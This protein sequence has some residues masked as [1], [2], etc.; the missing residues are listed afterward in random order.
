MKSKYIFLLI[1]AA[2][3]TGCRSDLLDTNPYNSIGS[4]VMWG[5]EKLADQGVVGIYNNL[6]KGSVGRRLYTYDSYGFTNDY[7][8]EDNL[9][10]GKSTVSDGVFQTYWQEH[11]EGIHRANDA[12]TNM[13]KA[14]MSAEKL[15]R[16]MAESKILRAYFYYK[17]NMVYKGVPL[18]LEPVEI[19]DMTAPRETEQRIWEVVIQD[20]T[21]AINEPNL[22]D[23]YGASDGEYGR[24]GK[25]V[26]YALRGKVYLWTK[27]WAKAESD[28]KK[29]G[30]LGHKLFQGEYKSL[31]KAENERN[32]EMIFS[33]QC[34]GQSGFGND[35]SFRYGGRTTFGS[36]WNTYYP[37]TDFVETFENADGSKF[38][39]DEVI[40]GYTDLPVND[41]VVY[42][43]R[44]EDTFDHDTYKTA[45]NT[46]QQY[47]EKY[48][49]IYMPDG[50]E[51]RI[52]KAYDNRDP[53]LKAS[54]ITPYSTYLGSA[55]GTDYLYTFRWPAIH[56][57]EGEPFDVRTDT[58]GEYHYLYRKFVAEG[59]NEI[60]NREYS[61][62]DIPL[63]R[64]ADVL[65]NLAE[66]LN[67]QG[68]AK[69]G[70]AI[71]VV[72][73]VRRR[74]GVAELNSNAHTQVAGQ[75]D[76]RERIRNERRWELCGE[77]I[78]FFDEMRWQTL[79]QTKFGGSN[80]GVKEIWGKM[81]RTYSW[82]GEHYYVWPIPNYERQMNTSLTQNPGWG[83]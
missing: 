43:L 12:I 51:E 33:V 4:G 28:F 50:N 32:E 79:H 74:A 11:Y 34:V 60:P 66:A 76:L 49:A 57:D 52:K 17:L 62:I 13:H 45:W 53:R 10:Q 46:I 5:S 23:R 16:L 71:A 21:D 36:C 19:N 58:N 30:E 77:G 15:G 24:V 54:I 65:L 35:I 75:A 18:Y 70:E 67:E 48:P 44:D 26:A 55:S 56:N 81:N 7:R 72:N 22:P 78:S 14:G 20:L 47:K 29:V 9:S 38:D 64:Y 41:R 42:F 25:S 3:L 31:F 39:W 82:G 2:A 8:D 80:P 59:S 61:P 27:E 6:Y 73:Q 40:P 68:A 1:I 83:N 63:I 69:M 37:S